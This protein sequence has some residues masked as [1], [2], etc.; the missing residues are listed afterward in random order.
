MATTL[1]G[2]WL[3]LSPYLP[4]LFKAVAGDLMANG[5]ATRDAGVAAYVLWAKHWTA[6][7][8]LPPP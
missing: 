5:R 8:G 7:G 6:V 1:P 4:G 2:G 3:T